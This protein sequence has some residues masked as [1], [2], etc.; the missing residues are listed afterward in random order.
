MILI[1]DDDQ[2]VRLSIGLALRRAHY[3]FEAVGTEEEAMQWVRRPEV[4]LVVLDMNLRL[5]TTGE[6]GLVMLQKFKILRPELPVILISAWATVPLAVRGMS[7][8]AFDVMT[9]PWSNEDL[10]EKIREALAA[11]AKAEADRQHFDTLD[12]LERRAV[13]DALRRCDGNLSAAAKLLGITRQ[14]LYRRIQKF[15]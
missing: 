1:V 8:G 5:S 13:E 15:D 14:A 2:S 12:T 11:S 7:G 10:V 9:K 4:K 3:D 6:Q